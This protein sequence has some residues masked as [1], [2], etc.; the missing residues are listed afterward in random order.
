MTKDTDK[1]LLDWLFAKA[2]PIIRWRLV[3]DFAL[4]VTKKEAARL[5]KGVL[6][7]E[8]A[9]RWLANLGGKGIHGSKDTYAENAMAKLVEYGLRAGIPE[10]DDKMLPYAEGGG[11][12]PEFADCFLVAAGYTTHDGLAA[13]FR[14]R[15]SAVHRTAQRADY[16]LYL[17]P[18]EALSV[19]KAWRGK[20]IYRPEFGWEDKLPIPKCCDLYAMAHWRHGTKTE[21]RKIEDIVA[22]VSHPSFQSTPGGYFWNRERNTCFSAGR[23]C[24]ACL[25]PER[26]VLFVELFARFRVARESS[27]FQDALSGLEGCRTERGTYRFPS[28]HLK[29]KRNSYHLYGGA[30]M[31]LGENRRKRDWIEVESTFRMLNIKRLMKMKNVPTKRCTATR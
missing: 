13:R 19:P 25:T 6:D 26:L 12:F 27:W 3:K 5:Q 23:A 10:F 15:L 21:R 11:W 31:G 9:K 8:E 29:E 4:P 2:E 16:D 24:L 7:T 28:D 1:T 30:H 14:K 17:A 22:Y 18:E 20:P